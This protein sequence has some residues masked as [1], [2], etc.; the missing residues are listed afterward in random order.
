M[1]RNAS[2][3]RSLAG[4]VSQAAWLRLE[5][6]DFFN[7]S[8]TQPAFFVNAKSRRNRAVSRASLIVEDICVVGMGPRRRMT[9]E[10]KTLLPRRAGHR[11]ISTFVRASV[12]LAE[13]TE[14]EETLAET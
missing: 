2:S 3:Q 8:D 4:P 11:S 1:N 13:L 7:T 9:R 12:H 6:N 10:S 5:S 14:L